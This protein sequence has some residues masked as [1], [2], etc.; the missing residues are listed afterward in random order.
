M[1]R[2]ALILAAL[3]TA[4]SA[5]VARPS[6]VPTPAWR[7]VWCWGTQWHNSETPFLKID[8][9]GSRWV[10]KT[11]HYMHGN[12]GR[13][14]RT[15]HFEGDKLSFVYWYEPLKR[16]AQCNFTLADFMM[17]GRCEAETSAQTWGETDSYL[18]REGVLAQP[19]AAA[20]GSGQP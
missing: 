5:A 2:W 8:R 19:T 9:Q 13:P 14:I 15:F 18:W 20:P 4:G 12:F 3:A 17:V 7:G 6:D 1:R 16:W 10:L 11:K